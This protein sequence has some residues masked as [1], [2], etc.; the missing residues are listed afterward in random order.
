M[1][2]TRRQI[3]GLILS[4]LFLLSV[5]SPQAQS[6]LNLQE[7]QRLSVGEPLELFVNLP[8][9]VL[10]RINVYV[11]EGRGLLSFEGDLLKQG[12]YKLGLESSPVLMAPG[13]VELQL[14]LFNL[15]PLKKINVDVLPNIL[16]VP[17][18][19]SIGVL[20]RTE[21]VMVVGFSPLLDENFQP[22]FPA[23][24]AGIALGDI[25][26]AV[27]GKRIVT[28]EQVKEAVAAWKPEDTG[29]TFT[30]KRNNQLHQKVVIPRYCQDTKSYRVGL[31]IRDNAGGVGTLTFYDPI[32]KKYGALG[33]VIA[34]Y[35]TNQALKIRQGKILAAYVEE[36]QK[37]KR[38]YPGEKVGF[39]LENNDLGNIEKNENCGIY[40]T[41]Y[42]V[43]KNPLYPEAL[44]IAYSTQ[45]KTGKAEILTVVE[46]QEINRYEIE[47]E[48]IMYGRQDSKNMIIRI[49]DK[50]LLNTTGGIVQGMSGSPIIQNGK[51]VGAVT[52]VF[53]NDP[54]RG[55]GV[56]IEN[57]LHEAEILQQKQKTLGINSQGFSVYLIV[58]FAENGRYFV[59]IARKSA[60]KFRFLGNKSENFLR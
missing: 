29:I 24:D 49:T 18:G 37:A 53:I 9:V 55:Y 16:L 13:K 19:H 26:V 6:Y 46:G 45:I 54:N 10:N 43:I 47:I 50:D 15:I 2:F 57:M 34:N 35:E 21:G 36:I 23:R 56:F 4:L 12:F 48:K 11:N 41:T 22:C 30:I 52:H 27:N 51:L 58:E 1:H 7:Q 60:D 33:H 39:F 44:P 42:Q 14:K 25:I 38:G 31:F 28:D 3:L 17:G 8:P 40:G 5:L 59:R 20:L 32:S